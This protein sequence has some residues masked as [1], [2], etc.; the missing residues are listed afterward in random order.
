MEWEGRAHEDSL[1]LELSCPQG[2]NTSYKYIITTA[3]PKTQT[4]IPPRL[5]FSR[6]NSTPE[7]IPYSFKA[8]SGMAGVGALGGPGSLGEI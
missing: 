8:L 6:Q 4:Y 1:E 5:G 7:K 2:P 3:S